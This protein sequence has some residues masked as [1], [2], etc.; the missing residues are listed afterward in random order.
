MITDEQYRIQ[1]Q[2]ISLNHSFYLD[3]ATTLKFHA[4]FS[5]YLHYFDDEIIHDEIRY[6]ETMIEPELYRTHFM[7][8][9]SGNS[10]RSKKVALTGETR[11]ESSWKINYGMDFENLRYRLFLDR[12]QD[13]K[14]TRLNSS[15]VAIS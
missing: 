13:R 3:R 2:V 12:S 9:Y 10:I 6:L 4:S 15:H 1:N 14:S 7:H 8:R 11:L 5:D